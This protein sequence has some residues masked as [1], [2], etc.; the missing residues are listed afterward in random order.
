MPIR[1][2]LRI[3]IFSPIGFCF[4][5][6]SNSNTF[7]IIVSSTHVLRPTTA[8]DS[9]FIIIYIISYFV[10]I[11]IRF[12]Y[13]RISRVIPMTLLIWIIWIYSCFTSIPSCWW[14][15]T[16]CWIISFCCYKRSINVTIIAFLNFVLTRIM[17][18][19]IFSMSTI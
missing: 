19:N 3:P 14:F 6:T 10:T 9:I 8:N 18:I 12:R 13:P 5:C 11:I 1:S 7:L 16:I 4:S 15:I 2:S 17:R